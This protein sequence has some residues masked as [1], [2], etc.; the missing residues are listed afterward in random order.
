MN[1]AAPNMP[2]SMP[3]PTHGSAYPSG[4]YVTVGVLCDPP[5]PSAQ[6]GDLSGP[7]QWA[8]HP[9]SRKRY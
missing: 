6:T 8:P 4:P 7:Q 9:V 5:S 3:A 1:D 2:P